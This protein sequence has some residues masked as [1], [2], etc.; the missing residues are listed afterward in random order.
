VTR[1]VP[2]AAV[3][4]VVVTVLVATVLV[5]A[6]AQE[7]RRS[8]APAAEVPPVAATPTPDQVRQVS[9]STGIPRRALT[10]YVAAAQT[11]ERDDPGCRIAW[12]TLA[13]IGA[14][15]S[16][17]GSFG[18]ARLDEQ[19]VARPLV[20]GVP[21]DGTG[22]NRAIDDT[23]GGRLD[24]DRR[25]D[26]AVGPMQFIPTTWRAWGADGDGDGRR[27]PHDIDDAALAAARYLCDAGTDLGGSE[28]WSRAVLTYNNSGAY[29]RKVAR[30]AA[31]YAEYAEAT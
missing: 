19:G 8:T 9:R 29:A 18:G 20:I 25:W 26:R 13:G 23:D 6:A 28:G 27:D 17:H 14:S 21:L 16:S 24:G 15:E 10:A 5:V 11:V 4:L 30:T 2:I 22:G 1:P 31:E 12:N 7:R 3:T